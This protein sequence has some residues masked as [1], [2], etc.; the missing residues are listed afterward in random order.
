VAANRVKVALAEQE[1]ATERLRQEV[2]NL[3]SQ[4]DLSGRLIEKLPQLAAHMPE[5]HQLSVLQSGS[6]D[7]AFDALAMFLARMVALGE[8]LGIRGGTNKESIP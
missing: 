4:S 8:T 2:R 6:G 1:V 7:G 3:I 5:I